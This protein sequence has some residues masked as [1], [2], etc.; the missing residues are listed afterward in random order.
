[1]GIGEA[2]IRD[3]NVYV[4]AESTHGFASEITL[5]DIEA[6]MSEYK[7]LGMVGTKELFQ[8]FGKME[9]A[10]KWNAPSEAILKACSDPRKS[11]DLMVRTSRE[12]YENGSVAR[13]EPVIYYL[14]GVSKNFNA[15]SF[16]PKDDTETE[17]K[18]AVSYFKMIQNGN[19]IYELDVDNNIFKIGGSDQLANYRA[20]LG[21]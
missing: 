9:S 17:T 19:E 3:A 13:E 4:G 16:K 7:A 15:G 8:G 12:V 2:K 6:S 1:M 18:F 11:V 5:P 10:I 14:K 20:N 21:L